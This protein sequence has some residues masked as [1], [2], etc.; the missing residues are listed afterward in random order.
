MKLGSFRCND[1]TLNGDFVI[2]DDA[3]TDSAQF[4]SYAYDRWFFTGDIDYLRR[5]KMTLWTLAE[6]IKTRPLLEKAADIA[7]ILEDEEWFMRS[8]ALL[9]GLPTDEDTSLGPKDAKWMLRHI[10]GIEVLEPGGSQIRIQPDLGPL[11]WAEGSLNVRTG[12]ICVRVERDANGTCNTSVSVPDGVEI[13]HDETAE[14]QA[15][16][17]Y[18]ADVGGGEVTIPTGKHYIKSLQLPSGV[19]LH[20]MENAV[21]SASRMPSDFTDLAQK[22]GCDAVFHIVNAEN[23]SIIGEKGSAIEG[24]NAYNPAGEETYRGPHGI[25]ADNASNVIVK[26][27]ELRNIGNWATQFYLS[28]N[29][30]F[31]DLRIRGGH[32][33]VHVRGCEHVRVSRC[34]IHTG[35]DCVAGFGNEDVLV[36]DCDLNTACS[37]FRFGGHHIRINRC[38]VIG[39]AE[40]PIRNSTSIPARVLNQDVKATGRHNMHSFFSYHTENSIHARVEPGDI[41]ITDCNVND[42][43][44]F[45]HYNLSGNEIW[46][47]GKPLPDIT[48]RNVKGENLLLSLCAYGTEECPIAITIDNA[49]F[50][51][52]HKRS[53]LIRGAFVKDLKLN[54]VQVRN[55]DGPCLRS[56]AGETTIE[57]EDIN[58]IAPA[59]EKMTTKF[60]TH[61][62]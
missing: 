39:P 49:I 43:E 28:S 1:D 21:L 48:F 61:H 8:R 35:D 26:G 11:N 56:W 44:R 33:G 19:T 36:E 12:T 53:E 27:V 7:R 52:K 9:K 24:N 58:G 55:V 30:I 15:E 54:N 31:E 32:D 22:N 40:F 46:Q 10:I 50:S 37:A 16:I 2:V 6:D 51:F 42:V 18:L 17:D 34:S 25:H 38:C 29:L 45:F 41:I 13:I 60:Y 59:I 5:N 14:I 57:A 62:V 4:F 3:S 23:V 47:N 20:L